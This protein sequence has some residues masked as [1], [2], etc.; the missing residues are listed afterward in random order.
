MAIKIIDMELIDDDI[1]ALQEE[2]SFLSQLDSPLVPAYYGSYLY[3]EQMWIVM[4]YLG[5]GSC[6]DLV[7]ETTI[8]HAQLKVGPMDEQYIAVVLRE[9]L[10]ALEYLHAE[11]KIH[12]DIKGK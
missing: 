1:S 6:L 9:T 2:I 5:G 4:E 12:R 10:R 11:G 8:C 7:K 3:K